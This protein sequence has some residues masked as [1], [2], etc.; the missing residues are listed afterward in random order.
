MRARALLLG[1]AL[2]AALG[3]PARFHPVAGFG[4]TAAALER[5]VW[6]PRRR[7]GLAHVTLLAGASAGLGRLVDRNLGLRALSLWIALGGRSLGREALLLA[8]ALERG[9]L[10]EARLRA[11]ALV[12]RD[13][14]QLDAA[15]LARAAVESVAENTGDAVVAPLFWFALGGVPGAFGHR[16]V[17]TLDAMIGNRSRRYVRFGWAAARLDDAAN[18]PAARLGAVLA[19][20]LAPVVGGSVRSTARVLLRDGHRHPSPNAGRLEAAFAGALGLELGGRNVYEGRVEHR[21]AIGEGRPACPQ[22]IVRAVRLCRAVSI[23]CAAL[24]AAAAR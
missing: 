1:F 20:L 9:S 21:P 22:D 13:P 16:A 5:R 7:N 2:D 17:N 10:G 24:C 18:W 23:G 8:E 19:V 11:P 6:R 4:R 3:D 12:G 15:E 14:S